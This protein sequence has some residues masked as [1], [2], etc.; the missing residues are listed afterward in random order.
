MNKFYTQTHAKNRKKLTYRKSTSHPCLV[1]FVLHTYLIILF[2]SLSFTLLKC[3]LFLSS[4]IGLFCRTIFHR[5]FVCAMLFFSFTLLFLSNHWIFFRFLLSFIGRCF[6]FLSSSFIIFIWLFVG[7]LELSH[8]IS[9]SL[10]RCCGVFFFFF[11]HSAACNGFQ[12]WTKSA[13]LHIIF[14]MKKTHF[15]MF[16]EFFI[17]SNKLIHTKTS[18]S[19]FQCINVKMYLLEEKNMETL[20]PLNI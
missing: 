7:W 16:G 3:G 10:A 8:P 19:S 1:T 5:V 6:F 18:L 4:F 11:V 12:V 14:K 15:G 17:V 9:M 13:A 2:L 20:S